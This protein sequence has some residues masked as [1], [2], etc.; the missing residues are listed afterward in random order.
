ML[1][2]GQGKSCLCSFSRDTVNLYDRRTEFLPARDEGS[3][4]EASEVEP[5][6]HCGSLT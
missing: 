5:V 4:E 6:D 1:L 2:P 3:Q